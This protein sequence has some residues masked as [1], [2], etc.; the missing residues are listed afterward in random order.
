MIRHIRNKITKTLHQTRDDWQDDFYE[1][2]R[3]IA[4]HPVVLRMKLYPHHGTTNCYQHCLHV[5]FYNYQFCRLLHLNARAAARAGMLH[6]L[7]LY[8]WHT[9]AA[10]TGNH[11]HGMTH[12]RI[13]YDN[14]NKF[15]NLDFIERDIILNHMWPV[16]LFKIPKTREGWITTISDKYC[17]ACETSQRK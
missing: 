5:A 16:T 2:I 4:E 15:F 14:A 17:G 11:F 8:D 7:F 1:C 13:A 9:H 3:D 6:D 10:K 12:P